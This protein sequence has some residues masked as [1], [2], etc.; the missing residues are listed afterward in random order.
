M[1][2]VEILISSQNVTFGDEIE[3]S[4]STNLC[5]VDNFYSF[6]TCYHLYWKALFVKAPCAK[7]HPLL[8]GTLT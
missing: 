3:P 5:D 4:T 8:R 2:L 1:A 7:L 6:G